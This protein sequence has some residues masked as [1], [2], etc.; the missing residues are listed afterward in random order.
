MKKI[1]TLALAL[2]FTTI[3]NLRA[4]NI[5]IPVTAN[6]VSNLFV[7]GKIIDSI[8]VT[9]TTTNITTF[10]FYDSSN[11]STTIVQAAYQNWASYAT[12]ITQVFTNESGLLVTNTF[13][14][15]WTYPTS[16]TASTNTRP[17]TVTLVAPASSMRSQTFRLLTLHGLNV[18]PNFDG[19]VEVE[20]RPQ[21]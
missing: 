13:V 3:I 9:A 14:G 19:I 15:R 6:V 7:N 1:T 2:L 8:S 17:V 11:T 21:Q 5:V 4:D 20:Y 18:I 16:V 10:K 12:N